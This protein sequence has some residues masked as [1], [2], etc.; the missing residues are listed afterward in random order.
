MDDVK[1]EVQEA[2]II[3]EA[4]EQTPQASEEKKEI[5]PDYHAKELEKLQKRIKQ[6]EYV[7]VEEKRKRKEAEERL[8]ETYQTEDVEEIV[9]KKVGEALTRFQNE[10]NKVQIEQKLDTFAENDA[11][12]ELIRHTFSGL[13]GQLGS[14]EERL[15]MAK[16]I[17]NRRRYQAN[18]QEIQNA[19]EA[20]QS[21][22]KGSASAQ[23]GNAE[24]LPIN[25][26]DADK[27]LLERRGIDPN[28]YYR[29]INN[30]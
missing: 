3:N 19:Y 21:A 23:G 25:L 7:T 13:S 4:E 10:Q 5:E 6:A 30:K 24:A 9:D 11:E 16:A 26:S 8:E 15:D 22:S 17:V 14:V 1:K 12:R 27:R 20:K 29:R 28:E 18:A 2:E